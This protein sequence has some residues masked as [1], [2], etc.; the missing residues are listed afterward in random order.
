MKAVKENKRTYRQ[1]KSLKDIP[2]AELGEGAY[3]F[4]WQF[5]GM[6]LLVFSV[7]FGLFF[8]WSDE[9]V[10]SRTNANIVI[11]FVLAVYLL[12]VKNAFREKMNKRVLRMNP[13]GIIY[14]WPFGIT[15]QHSY[16]EW[17]ESINAGHYRIGSR[18]IEFW[19]GFE[20]IVFFYNVGH[21]GERKKAEERYEMF[22][23]YLAEVDPML[24]EKLP[25]FTK[26]NID[27]LDKRCF[28]HRSRKHQLIV[29]FF[30]MFLFL[31]L[32]D[33][34]G[35]KGAVASAFFCG[36]IEI[37]VLYF[38][39]KGAYYNYKNEMEIRKKMPDE[40]GLVR[41][42]GIGILRPYWGFIYVVLVFGINYAMQCAILWL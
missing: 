11:M 42:D 28:Y 16:S 10:S 17:A 3:D 15:K 7:F 40:T 20:K 23:D 9:S 33:S 5:L 35:H 14:E 18:G 32:I 39:S 38:L 34:G 8:L 21:L 12:F 37:F 19:L 4:L 27:L 31:M 25:K 13:D 41:D 1:I 6:W 29:M 26:E 30:N 36:I 2:R 22:V 24:R